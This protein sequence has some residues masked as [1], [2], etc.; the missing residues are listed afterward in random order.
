MYY[1]LNLARVTAMTGLKRRRKKK[2]P[3]GGT[4][5]LAA[6]YLTRQTFEGILC[7]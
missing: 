3:P 2:V 4:I 5:F 1:S 6:H 7:L